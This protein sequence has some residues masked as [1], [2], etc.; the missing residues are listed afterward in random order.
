MSMRLKYETRRERSISKYKQEHLAR[1]TLNIKCLCQQVFR[2]T[3]VM[4][5]LVSALVSGCVQ[6][7]TPV[8]LDAYVETVTPGDA[9]P[10]LP[11]T[12]ESQLLLFNARS[13][14]VGVDLDS[15]NFITLC[16]ASTG[17]ISADTERILCIPE[18]VSS[19]LKFLSRLTGSTI[20]SL[21]EWKQT[22]LAQPALPLDGSAFASLIE[23]PDE[24]DHLAVYNDFGLEVARLKSM[25]SHGF[26]GPD[27]LIVHSPPL[28]WAFT[29]EFAQDTTTVEEAE[30]LGF[31]TPIGSNSFVR[32]DHSPYGVIYD[33]RD[34]IY[35]L[36]TD[37]QAARKVGEGKLIGVGERRVLALARE[38][39]LGSKLNVF[40]IGVEANDKP[41]HSVVLDDVSYGLV[42]RAEMAGRDRVLLQ[43]VQG[44]TCGSNRVEY[45]LKSYL[46]SLTSNTVKVLYDANEPHQAA[47]GGGGRYAVISHLDNCGRSM[48]NADLFDIQEEAIRQL[49]SEM[50][51]NVRGAAV[52][53]KGGHIAIMGDNQ[54]WL[55][56][57]S[58][59]DARVA[60]S[61][62][63]MIGGLRFTQ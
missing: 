30:E 59:L 25:T 48:G 55:L 20:L 14:W 17:L 62:E 2:V 56:D 24:L 38:G 61:G 27:H 57:G 44:K 50:R 7:V 32:H 34:L 37:E 3:G 8:G 40:E 42:Y 16:E 18:S 29:K 9:L 23:V 49:P 31:L 1:K 54:V 35:F 58:T 36:E 63:P 45:A 53:A 51:G 22:D 11:P 12:A 10:S 60:H 26:I 4:L 47:V 39:T 43:S 15:Q 6:D 52:S 41:L 5:C 46:V 28:I 21:V 19:P 13:G 33:D